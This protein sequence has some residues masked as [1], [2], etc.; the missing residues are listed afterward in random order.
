MSTFVEE[1]NLLAD[2]I[3][4]DMKT[5]FGKLSDRSTDI[6]DLTTLTTTAKTSL[7]LALNEVKSAV[8]NVDVGGLIDDSVTDPAKVWSSEKVVSHIDGTIQAI[9]GTAPETLNTIQELATA[10]ANNPDIIAALTASID[11]RIA[12]DKAQSFTQAQKD[13]ALANIGAAS[14]ISYDAFVASVGDLAAM[15]AVS[16]YVAARDGVVL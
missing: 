9:V 7:V 8:D 3:G 2:T 1:V 5:A 10:F 6:G 14:K 12:V 13:Q 11:L 16:R 4:A 15:N